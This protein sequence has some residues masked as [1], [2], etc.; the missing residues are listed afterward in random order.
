MSWEL[1]I[2][3]LA[4]ILNNPSA[5]RAYEELQRQYHLDGMIAE[6]EAIGFLIREKFHAD[7]SN[8]DKEQ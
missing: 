4:S 1:R 7:A 6:N 2:E 8:I 5:E 3:A